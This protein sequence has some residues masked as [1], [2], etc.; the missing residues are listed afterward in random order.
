MFTSPDCI[1]RIASAS[2]STARM[3]GRDQLLPRARQAAVQA[4]FIARVTLPQVTDFAD[5]LQTKDTIREGK[6]LELRARRHA[7]I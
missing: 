4:S 6:R 7:M 3:T 5:K 2:R 1:G